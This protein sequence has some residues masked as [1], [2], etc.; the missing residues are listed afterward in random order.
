MAGSPVGRPSARQRLI[1][2]WTY[3]TVAWGWEGVGNH[4]EPCI[5]PIPQSCSAPYGTVPY[6]TVLDWQTRTI[7]T[8]RGSARARAR[9]AE[10]RGDVLA[11]RPRQEARRRRRPA[12]FIAAAATEDWGGE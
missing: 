6:C 12:S 8:D 7:R 2:A 11:R 9:P 5:P 1:K 10:G 4:D 3:C